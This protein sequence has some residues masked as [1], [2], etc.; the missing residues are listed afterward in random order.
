ITA[1]SDERTVAFVRNFSFAEASRLLRDAAG[2]GPARAP[3]QITGVTESAGGEVPTARRRE[4]IARRLH[5]L[6]VDQPDELASAHLFGAR[7]LDPPYERQLE[8]SGRGATHTISVPVGLLPALLEEL[9]L[10]SGVAATLRVFEDGPVRETAASPLAAWIE[11]LRRVQPLLDTLRQR[12]GAEV[13]ELP[14]VID[15]AAS[16]S[17]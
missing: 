1:E 8:F 13:I 14:V 17:P 5:Q 15:H 9:R 10:R 2:S 7:T 3:D 12:D 16:R 4:Q 11:D 6:R